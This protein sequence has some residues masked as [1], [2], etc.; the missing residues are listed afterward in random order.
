MSSLS[1][2]SI[3]TPARGPSRPFANVSMPYEFNL[4]SARFDE[5][6]FTGT[7]TVTSTD[8]G[9]GIADSGGSWG[10]KFS[11]VPDGD[12]SPRVVAGTHG[13]VFTTDGGTR[14]GFIGAFVGVSGQ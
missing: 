1:V 8:P 6:G 4:G 14:A 2:S 9:I 7:T 13:E 5:R 3:R 12:G 10:G 11:I